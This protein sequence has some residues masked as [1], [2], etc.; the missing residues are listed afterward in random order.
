MFRESA[1]LTHYLNMKKQLG[2][3]ECKHFLN[4][5]DAEPMIVFLTSHDRDFLLQELNKRDAFGVDRF[6]HRI[7][8]QGLDQSLGDYVAALFQRDFQHAPAIFVDLDLEHPPL[9]HLQNIFEQVNAAFCEALGWRED[10][11]QLDLREVAFQ[12]GLETQL[13]V[14]NYRI[15]LALA[16]LISLEGYTILSVNHQH[17]EVKRRNEKREKVS[18]NTA[19]AQGITQWT[20]PSRGDAVHYRFR[21]CS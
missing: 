7:L 8:Y 5:S 10:K 11:G 2:I 17:I 12:R 16:E 6:L 20:Q 1:T 4:A 21:A 3:L 14:A 13:E 18:A 19:L 9:D 15:N